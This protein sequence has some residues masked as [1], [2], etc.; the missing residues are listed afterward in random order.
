MTAESFLV[1]EMCTA[2]F[3]Q[4]SLAPGSIEDWTVPAARRNTILCA[5]WSRKHIPRPTALVHQAQVKLASAVGIWVVISL[6]RR[7]T[8]KNL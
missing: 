8:G 1:S 2:T 3:V 4:A 7:M 6:S 5:E